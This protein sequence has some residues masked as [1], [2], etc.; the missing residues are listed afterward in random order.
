M[1]ESPSA[2][3]PHV[4]PFA[5][6]VVFYRYYGNSPALQTALTIELIKIKQFQNYCNRYV[7]IYTNTN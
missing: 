1:C 2:L 4:Q 6:L 3:L 5:A 7:N